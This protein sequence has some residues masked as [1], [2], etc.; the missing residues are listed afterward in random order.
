MTRRR[1]LKA[2]AGVLGLSALSGEGEEGSLRVHIGQRGADCRDLIASECGDAMP[3]RSRLSMPMSVFGVLER[4]PGMLV[5]RR[6]V[7]LSV[8]FGGAM[9]MRGKVV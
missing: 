2:S 1:F 6:V 9:G 3:G 8:L 4:L 5:S 7:L